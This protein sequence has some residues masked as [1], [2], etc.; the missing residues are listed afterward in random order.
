VTRLRIVNLN[1]WIGVLVKSVL[2]VQSIEPHGHKQQR[3]DALVAELKDRSADVVTLQ[4]CTPLPGFA[5]DLARALDYDVHWRVGNSGLRLLSFG[6]PAGIGRGEG[7]V[8]LA[9]REL[10]LT[11]LATRR[12]SGRGL[13]Q[14]WVSLQVGPVRVAVAC[15]VHVDG[16]PVI[17][18]NTHIRYGFP[19]HDAFW[20]GWRIMRE[21]GVVQ[22]DEPPSWLLKLL[23]DNRE[24]R[25]LELKR[26]AAWLG[27][28][29]REHQAPVVVG[30]DFNLDPGAPQI[31][32]F[33][34]ETGYTNILPRFAPGEL[35]WDPA[36][37]YNVGYGTSWTWDDGSPKSMIL[38]LMAY[39]DR[40]PQTP[41]H[42][43][44]SPG[45]T[46]TDGGVA[47][48]TPRDGILASDHYGV[49]ADVEV[50]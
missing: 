11:P 47:F 45:L 29:Q 49:W 4:E 36:A 24:Q 12:L 32:E 8:V 41:D 46:A 22:Q 38:Q 39:L 44:V 21:R 35:T 42:I 37:N 1:T 43:M 6:L 48:R 30:A 50:P 9:K 19:N 40:I 18:V 34:A 23:H 13:V 16:R 14:N 10:A 28:L 25:D 5:L 15:R 33:L 26:L 31:A 7:L 2:R 20:D 17:V 27:H 3:F